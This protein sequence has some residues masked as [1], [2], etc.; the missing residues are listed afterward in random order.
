MLDPTV[1]S[2]GTSA[3]YQPTN[4]AFTVAFDR[5]AFVL[6]EYNKMQLAANPA[7]TTYLGLDGSTVINTTALAVKDIIANTIAMQSGYGTTVQTG[8][9]RSYRIFNVNQNGDSQD[10]VYITQP[11]TGATIF[12]TITVTQVA[13]TGLT[14]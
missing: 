11:T 14:Y 2:G 5:D 12:G 3:N 4:T 1:T 10:K 8:Y 7:N 6:P 9:S 13:L